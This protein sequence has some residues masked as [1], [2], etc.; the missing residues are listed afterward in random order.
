MSYGY[1]KRLRGFVFRV[2]RDVKGKTAYST[3]DL[4]PS[5]S[6]SYKSTKGEA[7]AA[8]PDLACVKLGST[9]YCKCRMKQLETP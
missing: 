8:M 2:V 1:E 6:P 7:H 5:P 3:R 9:V 4:S